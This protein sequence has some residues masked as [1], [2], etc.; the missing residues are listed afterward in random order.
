MGVWLFR[1]LELAGFELVEAEGYD[2]LVEAARA[3]EVVPVG[4]V[5]RQGYRDLLTIR[6][7]EDCSCPAASS[8]RSSLRGQLAIAF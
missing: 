6:L 1:F 7:D 3:Q 2:E 8:E 4:V 5:L